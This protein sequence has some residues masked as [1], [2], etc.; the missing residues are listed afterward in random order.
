LQEDYSK[1]AQGELVDKVRVH[2]DQTRGSLTTFIAVSGKEYTW[3][4]NAV[5]FN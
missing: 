5:L 4:S 1:F 3:P 2:F